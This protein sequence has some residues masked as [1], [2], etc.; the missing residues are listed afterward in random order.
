MSEKITFLILS[1]PSREYIDPVRFISNESSG[2]MGKALADTIL[3]Q[4]HNLIFIS[5]VAEILPKKTEVIKAVSAAEMFMQVKNNFKKADIIISCAA[6]ADF[7]PKKTFKQKIN[8]TEKF[9]EIKLKKN[10]DIIAYC[11]KHKKHRVVVGFALEPEKSFQNAKKKIE[12]K[13][14][15]FIVLNGKEALGA[16]K[17]SA[18]IIMPAGNTVKI[19]D[20]NKNFIAERIINASIKIFKNHKNDQKSS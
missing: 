18:V 10:A 15:D 13:N 20:R 16:D 1:G 2:K 17:T 12:D 8:K 5:G 19:K 11:G 6:V 9:N 7:S 14:L 4:K 3:K